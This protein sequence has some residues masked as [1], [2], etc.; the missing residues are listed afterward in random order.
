M[1]SLRV[2]QKAIHLFDFNVEE[3]YA[4]ICQQ[5]NLLLSTD[6]ITPRAQEFLAGLPTRLLRKAAETL[7]KDSHVTAYKFVREGCTLE[8]WRD[9]KNPHTVH[10]HL[11]VS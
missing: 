5:K 8:I 10:V 2:D 11:R 4:Q 1:L 7:T 6:H 3:I 9:D